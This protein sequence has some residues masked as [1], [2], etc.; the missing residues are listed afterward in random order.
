MWGVHQSPQE[1]WELLFLLG[2]AF[3]EWFNI[4][5]EAREQLEGGTRQGNYF[6]CFMSVGK[7]TSF[8]YE[9]ITDIALAWLTQV[10]GISEAS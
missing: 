3:N 1:P 2:C 7:F 8:R 4:L 5:H 9:V 10:L 6:P